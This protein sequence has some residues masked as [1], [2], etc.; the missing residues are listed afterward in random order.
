MHVY[1]PWEVGATPRADAYNYLETSDADC[2]DSHPLECVLHRQ[3][4]GGEGDG[5]GLQAYA[6]SS[7][8]LQGT[9]VGQNCRLLL[10]ILLG[11]KKRR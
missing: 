2:H 8:L 6:L 7:K 5:L 9:I 4:S 10:T 3:N 11:M 1:K